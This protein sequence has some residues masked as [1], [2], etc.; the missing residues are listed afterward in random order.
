M[1]T[2]PALGANTPTAATQAGERAEARVLAALGNLPAP[3]QFFH[4][5]EWRNLS[6]E[7]EVI[8]EAD[9]LVFHPQ[10]GLVF[11]EVKAGAVQVRD[12]R[13]FYASGLAMKQ[14]P[15]SQARR[16]RYALVDKLCQRLGRE[17]VGGV[18]GLGVTH[19]VWFPDVVWQGGLPSTEAPSR[20]FL[21]DRAALADPAPALLRIFREAMPGAQP[22]TRAQQHVLK[23]LL[24]PDCHGLVPLATR[25]DDA[26]HALHQATEQ[27]VAVLRM[28]RTQPRLLVEGGAGTGKTVLAVALAR[29]HA[30]L[31][32]SV[33]L[34]CFNKA[35]AQSLA[36]WLADVPGITVLPFHELARTQAQAA[37]LQYVVPTDAAAQGRF[38]QEESAEL[39]LTAAE[40]GGQRFDTLIVDEAADFA[41]TWWVAL[42]ALGKPAFSW[43]CFY[44]RQQCLFQATGH[45]EPPFQA[46][47]MVLDANLRNTRA[48]GEMA[49][50]LG[51][52]EVPKA[53]RVDSGEAPVTLLSASYEEMATQ[54]R[55]LL[56]DLL[57][58]QGLKPEQ[59]IVLSPYR[60][61]NATATWAAGLEGFAH[62]TELVSPGAGQLRVGTIQG[63]K[64]LEADVVV[65]VGID[66]RCQRH[67]ATLYVGAS[68]ARA[69]LYV[70]ALADAG[71][72]AG[73]A[74]AH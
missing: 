61:S 43:Y 62:T 41:A 59:V 71:L 60:H 56:R 2:Q 6:F 12:G 55:T 51:R 28:L 45:W 74:T 34:T 52:Y 22:W 65:I 5:V 46:V 72:G 54:L 16:N 73:E 27:Q 20:A 36:V 58:H 70:L 53:F 67:P 66:S 33:L 19:A 15:F 7:G 40:M 49:A 69:A 14:S 37:G 30:A 8:G 4:A 26:V 17:V 9:V 11:F 48:I 57:R 68:R 42:E 21:L 38:F 31:G 64:G 44:D 1:L 29:E 23:E 39:L 63:F 24:A 10:H 13:W 50:R 47:P 3:W 18:D 25:V 32:K 35:L